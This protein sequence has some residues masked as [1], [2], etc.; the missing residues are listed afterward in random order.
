MFNLTVTNNYV[1]GFSMDNGNQIFAPG[2]TYQFPNL[3]GL[4]FIQIPGM[5]QINIV[6]L[7]ATKLNRY[8]N[9]K[10]PWTQFT[11][12]GVVRYSGLDA[13]FRYEGQGQITIV[14]DQVG[15]A[16]VHFEQGG[17]MVDLADLQVT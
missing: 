9:P 4:H 10:I 7:G 1:A 16:T 12:G 14:I 3:S 15:S 8:T 6:D 5:G 13:Y 2:Q 17:M 11:W